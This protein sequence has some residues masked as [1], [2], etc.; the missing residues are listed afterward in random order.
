M[1]FET[2]DQN[3]AEGFFLHVEAGSSGA[4]QGGLACGTRSLRRGQYTIVS[5]N[6]PQNYDRLLYCNWDLKAETNGDKMDLDCS[7]FDLADYKYYPNCAREGLRVNGRGYCG[8]NGPS[9]TNAGNLNIEFY[10]DN[11]A[12]HQGFSC[13][14]TVHS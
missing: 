5:K 1:D 10:A 7:T 3:T 11:Y 6:F 9:V 12:V 4:G 8:T 14:V 13:T 2:D